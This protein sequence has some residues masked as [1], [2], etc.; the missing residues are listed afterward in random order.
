MGEPM[1]KTSCQI[2]CLAMGAAAGFVAFVMLIA[3]GGWGFIQ[4]VFGAGVIFILLGGLLSW[5][6]CTPLPALGGVQAGMAEI[7]TIEA[8]GSRSAATPAAVAQPAAPAAPTVAAPVSSPAAE[9]RSG[10]LLQGEAELAARKGTWTYKAPETDAPVTKGADDAPSAPA[11]DGPASKPATLTAARGGQPD[12]LKEIKGI[13]PKLETMLHGMGF[14]HF[15]QI[16][17][18]TPTEL[19]WV[20]QNLTGFKGRA[21]RDNWVDQAKILASGGETA[22]SKRVEDGDVY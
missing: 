14:F 11:V 9:V 20:D 21:S 18:W 12:N 17:A 19:A 5:I 8:P 3:L 15:D 7:D 1:K 4:A 13:G 22:F 6:L 2:A 16:A 10:T